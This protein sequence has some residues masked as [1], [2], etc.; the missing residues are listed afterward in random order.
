MQ[1]REELL[2]GIEKVDS[3]VGVMPDRYINMTFEQLA[4]ENEEIRKKMHDLF[5]EIQA[6]PKKKKKK[7]WFE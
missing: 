4:A 5:R 1:T 6:T 7:G 3:P 2:A